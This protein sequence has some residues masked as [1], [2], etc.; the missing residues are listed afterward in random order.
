MVGVDAPPPA[1]DPGATLEYPAAR[2]I[3]PP[4]T[5][6]Y[7]SG[8]P[9]VN[10]IRPL[11]AWSPM[12]VPQPQKRSVWPWIIGGVAIVGF[13]G[14]GLLILIL[15]LANMNTNSNNRAINS[16]LAN[17]N[18]NYANANSNSATTAQFTDDFSTEK[19]GTGAYSYG[20]LWYHA[21]E[22]HM[23]AIN[24]GYIVMLG[25]TQ[26]YESGN[27]IVRITARSVDGVSPNAGYGLVV[28]EKSA[29]SSEPLQYA[30]LIRTDNKPAYKVIQNRGNTQKQIVAWTTS[31]IIRSGTS[32]NQ[33][34][35]RTF[36]EWLMF[37]INGQYAT[38]FVNS[39]G[40]LGGRVG[41]YT[42]GANEVAFDDLEIRR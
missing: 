41:L 2:A 16:R 13:M 11:P 29:A 27:G 21:G 9:F 42:T 34:E 19:W 32:P 23:H 5:A 35:V 20:T 31:P 18:A 24:G 17:R 7:R 37:Y 40:P 28:A 22:Y 30:F 33:L 12:P 38:R 10:Q 3:T 15:A 6:A 39:A 8:T 4:P 36:N 26:A 25:P 14:F 1:Y